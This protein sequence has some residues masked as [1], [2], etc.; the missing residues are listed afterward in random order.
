MTT[1]E[2]TA[3][4]HWATYLVYGET[5]GL[6]DQDIEACDAWLE[7]EGVKS[8]AVDCVDAGFMRYHDAHRFALASD[9]QTYAFLNDDDDEFGARVDF[10][11]DKLR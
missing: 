5:D 9:C 2:L 3:P 7:A 8:H 4:S 11:M 6:E 1:I 10:E